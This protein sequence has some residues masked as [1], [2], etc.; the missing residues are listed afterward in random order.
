MRGTL[1]AILVL[2]A[3]L[4]SCVTPAEP[5]VKYALVYGVSRYI[6]ALQEG[7]YPNLTL[8]DD[9]A[10]ALAAILE[11]QG[12]VVT[13]RVNADASR[14]QLEADL[15]EL[16][17]VVGPRD[18]VLVYYSG[19]GGVLSD[20]GLTSG[21][22]TRR[23]ILPYGSISFTS[24]VEVDLDL[25]VSD[26]EL[27]GLLS[28]LDTHRIVVILDSCNSGGF[29]GAGADV[30]AVPPDYDLSSSYDPAQILAGALE[31][32][33]AY[34]PTAGA[35]P[36]VLSAAG[37]DEYSWESGSLG[38]GVFTYYLL[39]AAGQGDL[40]GDGVVTV[41]EAYAYTTAGIDEYWNPLF[42]SG[43]PATEN[44]YHPHLTGG[45]VDFALFEVP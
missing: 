24:F 9:D 28:V 36:Y 30:D 27:G 39:E 44:D 37:A 15:G 26:A 20:F 40:D 41:V 18:L 43:Y 4:A 33:G 25:A 22:D 31:A 5:G 8:S 42:L 35:G 16:A 29:V 3:T 10:L 7:Q 1:P 14:A 19:H 21:T 38:Q 6:D 2:L 13:P 23:W 34:A 17:S 32:Y 12:Y 11:D 45:A